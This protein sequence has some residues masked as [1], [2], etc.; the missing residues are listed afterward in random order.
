MQLPTQQ[1]FAP[2]LAWSQHHNVVRVSSAAFILAII[3]LFVPQYQKP[4]LQYIGHSLN[5]PPIL[6]SPFEKTV[7]II[8]SNK[9]RSERMFMLKK[10]EPFF[11]TVHYSM[12]GLVPGYPSGWQDLNNDNAID[13]YTIYREVA[14]AM[15]F[16]LDV[17]EGSPESDINSL[18]FFHFDAWIDPMDFASDNFDQMWLPHSPDGLKT[19][20]GSGGIFRCMNN[21]EEWAPWVFFEPPYQNHI[22]A[23]RAIEAIQHFNY[24]YPG[25]EFCVGWS[26]IYLIPRRFW[27][28]WIFLSAFFNDFGVFQ[29]VAIPTMM[30]IIDSTRRLHPTQSVMQQMGECWGGCCTTNP[31]IRDLI[32]HRCGHKFNYADPTGSKVAG[33]HYDR[34][35][36]YAEM[37][38]KPYNRT[39][40]DQWNESA[41]GRSRAWFRPRVRGELLENV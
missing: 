29:E 12:P 23:R 31:D 21:K 33:V 1:I 19:D 25:G 11:H 26:D 10:Y 38:G 40:W 20:A 13:D 32:T 18:L 22:H 36:R 30:K 2:V 5:P 37:L 9:Q 27:A 8:R 28:D 7:A 35:D 15:Q 6:K 14:V 24:P 34:L 4:T 39:T 41:N 17:P 3:W 16:I